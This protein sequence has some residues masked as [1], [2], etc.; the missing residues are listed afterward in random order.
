M[1][2][3]TIT[4]VPVFDQHGSYTRA[5]LEEIAR[6]SQRRIDDTGDKCPLTLGHTP[7]R[8][9]NLPDPPIVGY[10]SNFRVA[11]FG[12]INPRPCIFA[13]FEVDEK[14]Q[15]EVRARPRRSVE[16]WPQD[17]I[18]DPI[19]LLGSRTPQRDLGLL[20][21][22]RKP[23]AYAGQEPI[24]Y[25]MGAD[26]MLDAQSF[27]EV[28]METPVGKWI[29]KQMDADQQ[30]EAVN[31]IA[32]DDLNRKAEELNE[33][34]ADDLG[35][36]GD[37]PPMGEDLGDLGDEPPGDTLGDEP[38][39]DSDAPPFGDDED[40]KK[41]EP[42]KM[43][44]NGTK[45]APNEAVRMERDQLAVKFANAEARIAELEAKQANAEAKAMRSERERQFVQ[46]ESEGYQFSRA[47]EM[48]HCKDFSPE[49][50]DRHISRIRKCYSRAPIGA[51]IYTEPMGD[52][53]PQDKTEKAL[54]RE[55][56]Q[57]VQR[58]MRD[59]K[60]VTYEKAV[61]AVKAAG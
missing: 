53:G 61:E 36:P 12:K 44:R 24:R 47:E 29:Q 1:A 56:L 38:P 40:E 17:R 23:G 41:K 30:A 58:Y 2:L 9:S 26:P 48:D 27:M 37:E 49:Q 21:F 33:P 15:D 34:D 14:A 18:I 32:A 22:Q 59:N 19:A 46:L 35:M 52:G 28:F 3:I 55:G 39:M 57:K 42:K 8:N 54:T 50:F 13:D 51:R 16:L 31:S 20:T 60:G 6:N 5:D 45:V 43:S 10:A 11:Q 25:E 4:D 7:K